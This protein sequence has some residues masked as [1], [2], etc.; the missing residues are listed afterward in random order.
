MTELKKCTACKE[1]K[2]I[3]CFVK[4]KSRS[5]GRYPVCR[6][7]RKEYY[8]GNRE[9]ILKQ[10]GEYRV[11]NSIHLKA[12]SRAYAER[13]FFYKTSANCL[14]RAEELKGKGFGSGIQKRLCRDIS[15]MWKRQ[16]GICPMSGR[17][18]NKETAQLDHIIPL[19][20]GGNSSIENL[21]WVHRDVNYAKRDLLDNEFLLL[22]HE[23]IKVAHAAC[24]ITN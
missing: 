23:V 10:Y 6:Q 1:P 13:R 22:C 16:R 12:R 9:R 14:S 20:R 24:D 18:L 19:K 11:A 21:R 7:C 8:E 15:L 3:G 5:D 4:D 17:R 2:E